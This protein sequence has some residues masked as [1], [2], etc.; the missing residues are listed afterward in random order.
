M[1]EQPSVRD[2][3]KNTPEVRECENTK[4]LFHPAITHRLTRKG[5]PADCG[6]KPGDEGGISEDG[7]T[8]HGHAR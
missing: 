2:A 4:G 8:N 1:S 5:N 7:G 6:R 3:V